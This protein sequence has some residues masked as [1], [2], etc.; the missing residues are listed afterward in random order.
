MEYNIL[1]PLKC[2]TNLIMSIMKIWLKQ[3]LFLVFQDRLDAICF[4]KIV[5]Y[6][7]K[8]FK[9]RKSRKIYNCK[10]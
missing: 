8:N 1:D 5:G 7:K 4:Q 9:E 6:P 10:E 3:L 2:K